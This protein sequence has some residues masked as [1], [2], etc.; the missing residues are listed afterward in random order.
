MGCMISGAAG[1]AVNNAF[2]DHTIS[3]PEGILDSALATTINGTDLSAAVAGLG[4]DAATQALFDD[5][6]SET[7]LALW[8]ATSK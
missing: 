2:K 7:T 1:S 8:G 3:D 4:A 6:M 5:D